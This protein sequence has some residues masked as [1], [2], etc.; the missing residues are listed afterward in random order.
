[1]YRSMSIFAEKDP[2]FEL[3]WKIAKEVFSFAWNNSSQW[4]FNRSTKDLR[5]LVSVIYFKSNV[6]IVLVSKKTRS[7]HSCFFVFVLLCIQKPVFAQWF[8]CI[9]HVEL[10]DTMNRTLV[11]CFVSINCGGVHWWLPFVLHI[12]RSYWCRLCRKTKCFAS[13]QVDSARTY[14]LSSERITKLFCP[15]FL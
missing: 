14:F 5:F 1:M 13:L 3:P 6:I 12:K 9:L 2:Y 8:F 11:K 7:E 15:R 10:S 4:L